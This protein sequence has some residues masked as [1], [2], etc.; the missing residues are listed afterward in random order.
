MFAN[1]QWQVGTSGYGHYD[2]LRFDATLQPDSWFLKQYERMK[3]PDQWLLHTQMQGY[4][5]Q[6]T[7][8]PLM[9]NSIVDGCTVTGQFILTGVHA[10][11][12]QIIKAR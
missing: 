5:H 7:R 1:W 2:E 9:L 11:P 4:Y 3:E 10:T 12:S 6:I 8:D